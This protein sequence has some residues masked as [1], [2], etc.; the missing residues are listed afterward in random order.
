MRF[1]RKNNET[2][3]NQQ[4]QKTNVRVTF[5]DLILPEKVTLYGCLFPVREFKKRQMFC[6][7]CLQYNHT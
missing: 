6:V 2:N 7:K 4:L 1:M 3:E 5:A